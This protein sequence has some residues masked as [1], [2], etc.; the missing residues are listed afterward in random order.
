MSEIIF[1][2][3]GTTVILTAIVVLAR[4]KVRAN[5]RDAA[6]REIA[7]H[8]FGRPRHRSLS[9]DVRSRPYSNGS[10]GPSSSRRY[11]DQESSSY[12]IAFDALLDNAEPASRHHEPSHHHGHST[13]V[14]SYSTDTPSYSH[15]AGHHHT[16]HD[17]GSFGG[18]TYGGNDGGGFDGGGG[19]HGD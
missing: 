18:D 19:H 17:G 12:P 1:V 15:D 6:A 16:S 13:Q 3:G 8:E 10:T 4:L 11:E 9:S 5:K 7:R 14:E 2:L